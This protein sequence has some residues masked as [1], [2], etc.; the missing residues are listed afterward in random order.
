MRIHEIYTTDLPYFVSCI[1]YTCKE[2]RVLG[3]LVRNIAKKH[4][5]SKLAVCLTPVQ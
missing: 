4:T 5:I 3:V 1:E 2:S